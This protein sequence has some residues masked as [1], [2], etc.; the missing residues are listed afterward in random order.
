VGALLTTSDRSNAG[1]LSS[2]HGWYLFICAKDLFVEANQASWRAA[3]FL[4]DQQ[5]KHSDSYQQGKQNTD[6]KR[7]N[8]MPSRLDLFRSSAF[9]RRSET[10]PKEK[11]VYQILL[12]TSHQRREAS[13]RR[14]TEPT[15]HK[16][17]SP[18]R[19]F[20]VISLTSPVLFQQ[21]TVHNPLGSG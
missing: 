20:I 15:I 4:A 2:A 21:S 11:F 8:R 16:R 14:L 9:L 10:Q 1:F 7:N 12:S 17:N 3:S 18:R 13:S 6:D 19:Q 5:N